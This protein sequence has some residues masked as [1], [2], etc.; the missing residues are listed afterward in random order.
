MESFLSTQKVEGIQTKVSQPNGKLR[1]TFRQL[2]STY[3]ATGR[4]SVNFCQLSVRPGELLS[5]SVNFPC[6]QKRFHEFS[7]R[8]GNFP[9][10]SIN[11]PC[12]RETFCQVPSNLCVAGRLSVNLSTFSV[13]RRLSVNF[14]CSQETFR[15]LLSTFRT[16]S[17]R[18]MTENLSAARK[19]DGSSL[20]FS[21]NYKI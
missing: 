1:E 11:F 19:V 9:S 15:Q 5:N 7:V 2:K 4:P 20:K 16:E 18:K 10:S 12:C 6:G 8:P 17:S 14:L 13:V 3:C 21:R